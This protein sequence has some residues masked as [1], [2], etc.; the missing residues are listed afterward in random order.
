V[1]AG[2]VAGVALAAALA[3]MLGSVLYGVGSFDP[4]AWGAALAV[5]LGAAT[6]A[7]L[8]PARRALRVDPVT[9]LRT[10]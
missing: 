4:I 6:A 8:V 7:H 9:A 2:T 1:V 10:E 3:Q 5:L